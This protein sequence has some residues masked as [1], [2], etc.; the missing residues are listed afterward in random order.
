MGCEIAALLDD[1]G[2]AQDPDGLWLGG[3]SVDWLK[4]SVPNMPGLTFSRNVI[5]ALC[6]VFI[7]TPRS[8]G[9][10]E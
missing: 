2:L 7:F 3:R 10:S 4:M 1:Y 9:H 6:R 5:R 8:T